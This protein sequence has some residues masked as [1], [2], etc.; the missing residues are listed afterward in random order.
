MANGDD[1]DTTAPPERTGYLQSDP[2]PPNPALERFRPLMAGMPPLQDLVQRFR[3]P[4]QQLSSPQEVPQPQQPPMQLPP[5]LAGGFQPILQDLVQRFLPQF[6]PQQQE[7]WRSPYRMAPGRDVSQIG[8]DWWPIA[9]AM[10]Y[11]GTSPALPSPLES[12]HVMGGAGNWLKQFASPGVGQ[13]YGRA[14][15]LAMQL[16]PMLDMMSKGQFSKNYWAAR[17]GRLKDMQSE[18]LLNAEM[19]LQQHQQEL[20]QYREIMDAFNLGGIDEDE[21]NRRLEELAQTDPLKLATLKN[22][23]IKALGSLLTEE[24]R[25]YRDMMAGYTSSKKAAGSADSELYDQGSGSGLGERPEARHPADI[26]QIGPT[27]QTTAAG[28]AAT[29]Q[30]QIPSGSLDADIAK[31]TGFGPG[32]ITTAHAIANGSGNIASYKGTD[33][34]KL[35]D[36]AAMINS[37][38]SQWANAPGLTTQ[39]KLDEIGKVD[40][41][42]RQTLEGL[43]NYDLNLKDYNSAQRQR[44]L[45]LLGGIT[46]GQFSEGKF[47]AAQ[48]YREPGGKPQQM[49]QS[50]EGFVQA[51][52]SVLKALND[53]GE[54]TRIPT[55][56]IQSLYSG[57]YSGDDRYAELFQSLNQMVTNA[58]AI[59]SGSGVTRVTLVNNMLRHMHDYASPAQ[60]RSQMQVDGRDAYAKVRAINGGWQREINP[61]SNAPGFNPVMDD[62]EDGLQRMNPHTGVMPTDAPEPL[63]EV[64]KSGTDVAD[65]AKSQH[66]DWTP[67]TKDKVRDYRDYIRDNENNPDPQVQKRIQY[68][69]W[70]LMQS[71]IL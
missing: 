40:Q 35:A 56:V 5:G 31:H 65:W 9:G 29:P 43:K 16:A 32:G 2:P 12:L 51:Q 47:A 63:K 27:G 13:Y 69:R 4:P 64:G 24:D 54:N 14:S 62:M 52:V 46:N 49:M 15:Q 59:Q 38:V 20:N 26:P 53:L 21:A 3:P 55:N 19:G 6:R 45:P 71:P 66:K 7:P 60:I 34:S 41:D 70:M 18:M 50:V 37:R 44:L 61:N 67:L 42:T 58:A 30:A 1:T 39:Q 17:S 28:G 33:R 23:G 22:K 36:A 48:K 57:N 11:P 8:Q 10:N 25:R 68:F